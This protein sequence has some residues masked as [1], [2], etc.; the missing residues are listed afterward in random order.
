MSFV[1]SRVSPATRH[2]VRHYVEM[3]VVMFLGMG[4]LAL[5]ARWAVGAAGTSYAEAPALMFVGDGGDDDRPDGR[6]DAL[7][8]P[9]LAAE[10]GD[11]RLDARADLRRHRACSGPGSS[12]TPAC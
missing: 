10:R 7:S 6:L 8:R 2:F 3:V 1:S 12:R 9:R 4:V 11:V 5:P